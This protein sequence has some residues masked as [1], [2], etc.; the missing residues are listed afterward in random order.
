MGLGRCRSG[1][2]KNLGM[3]DWGAV[4]LK[5]CRFLEGVQ[6]SGADN[7]VIILVGR[8]QIRIFYTFLI[9]LL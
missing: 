5:G 9:C 4:G 2:L 6:D 7:H 1:G 8:F 3:W